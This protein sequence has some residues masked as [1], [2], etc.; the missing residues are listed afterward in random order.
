MKGYRYIRVSSAGAVNEPIFKIP[1]KGTEIK[2]IP[3]AI[4]KLGTKSTQCPVYPNHHT[5]ADGSCS[6]SWN[7]MFHLKSCP[8]TK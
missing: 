1:L 3:K 4:K 6:R 5:K 7:C 2:R 8:A